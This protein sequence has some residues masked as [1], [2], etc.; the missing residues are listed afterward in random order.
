MNN[1]AAKAASHAEYYLFLNND[2]EL[3]TPD[4]IESML[5]HA[6]RPEV[7]AVGARLF[8]PTGAVQHEGVILGIAGGSAGNVDHGGYFGLGETIRNCSA[9][10]AA[11][12]L[13]RAEAFWDLGG[14]DEQLR[15]AF[16][17]VDFCLR[18]RRKGY[19]IVYTPYARLY[20]YESASRGSLHPMEDEQFFRDRWG[21]PGEYVDPYY[22]PNLDILRPFTLRV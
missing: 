1:T 12:M 19:Q 6:Q 11:C 18:A 7:A 5:E 15:V 16:N 21:N 10:T 20:H 13:T 2:T 22:N 3:I 4:W 17:D 9:V 8:Y 14:L